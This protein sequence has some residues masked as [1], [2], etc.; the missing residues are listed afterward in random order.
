MTLLLT[1]LLVLLLFVKVKLEPLELFDELLLRL[2]SLSKFGLLFLKFVRRLLYVAPITGPK[3]VSRDDEI[4]E[5][6]N[7]LFPDSG[8]SSVNSRE[9]TS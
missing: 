2:L 9:N 6:A 8:I 1:L 7:I 3:T 4:P 5:D